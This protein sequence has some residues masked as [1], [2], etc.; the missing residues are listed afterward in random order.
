M[1]LGLTLACLLPASAAGYWTFDGYAQKLPQVDAVGKA[2]KAHADVRA[3]GIKLDI[4][5]T[6]INGKPYGFHGHFSWSFRNL[7]QVLIPGQKV[8]FEGTV[9]HLSGKDTPFSGTISQTSDHPSA[10]NVT[11]LYGAA[12][13]AGAGNHVKGQ[14]TVPNGPIQNLPNGQPA[15]L[16]L[17]F[18]L[19]SG[20]GASATEYY[21]FRWNPGNPPSGTKPLPQEPGSPPPTQVSPQTLIDTYN[22]GGVGNSPTQR[23]ILHL[24]V[25]TFITQMQTYHYNQ[26]RGTA[27]PGTLAL[28]S[29][30]DGKTYGPWSCNGAPGQGGVANAFWT[31]TPNVTLPPGDY[32]VVDSDPGTWS[33]NAQ[34]GN[35]GFI[36]VLGRP[37]P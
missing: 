16:L 4:N 36:Q 21:R 24:K 3:Q 7:N 20:R 29:Q 33:T 28:V 10:G 5:C 34:S 1:L 31:A 2:C 13:S 18:H 9:S 14:W 32:I 26:G 27:A 19:D 23:A 25:A 11:F 22:G 37:A 30:R 8:D 15:R 35:R 17:A 6:D 12:G